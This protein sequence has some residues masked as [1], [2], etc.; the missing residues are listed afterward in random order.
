M[1]HNQF[2][3]KRRDAALILNV[4][5]DDI[6]SIH[7]QLRHVGIHRLFPRATAAGSLAV[8][9]DRARVV[10]GR[11]QS[12]RLDVFQID[13]LAKDVFRIVVRSPDPLR[14]GSFKERR[15]ANLRLRNGDGF[16]RR[17]T[18]N[19][20]LHFD[21]LSEDLLSRCRGYKNCQ[22]QTGFEDVHG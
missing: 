15:I 4:R 18:L 2:E 6:R 7:Q 17:T 20:R 5:F 3:H 16:C 1:L 8:D 9:V 19:R 21:L 22:D 10:G 12:S 11:S 13:G 14:C